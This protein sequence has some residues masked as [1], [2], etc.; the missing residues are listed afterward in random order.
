MERPSDLLHA[1]LDGSVPL[2]DALRNVIAS[3]NSDED[4]AQWARLELDGYGAD[5]D[6]PRYREVRA[7]LVTDAFVPGGM[8]RKQ[9]VQA[10]MLP[11]KARPHLS[12][13]VTV[14]HGVAFLDRALAAGTS[15]V[16]VE[17]PAWDSIGRLLEI[18][19]GNTRQTERVYFAVP[20]VALHGV[21]DAIRTQLVAK[22]RDARQTADAQHS[23]ARPAQFVRPSYTKR[24]LA[25]GAAVGGAIAAVVAFV[26]G[27]STI[28]EFVLKWLVGPR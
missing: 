1:A 14:H 22:L 11:E 8:V 28:T 27:A 24:L 15:Y 3:R 12:N 26:A 4:L 9:R 13:V 7:P 5:D 17:P 23:G 20:T 18:H 25:V 19:S 2:Q 10:S 21:L 16:E 6:L